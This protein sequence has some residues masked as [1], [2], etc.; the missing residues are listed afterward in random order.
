MVET[1]FDLRVFGVKGL[2]VVDGS[3]LQVR[4]LSVNHVSVQAMAELATKFILNSWI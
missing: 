1:L 2:R 4:Q 3:V